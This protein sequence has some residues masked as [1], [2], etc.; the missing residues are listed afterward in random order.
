MHFSVCGYADSV[1][2]YLSQNNWL[3]LYESIRKGKCACFKSPLLT[4]LFGG[5]EILFQTSCLPLSS[6]NLSNSRLKPDRFLEHS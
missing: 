4:A 5:G 6:I 1:N 3:Y 2:S